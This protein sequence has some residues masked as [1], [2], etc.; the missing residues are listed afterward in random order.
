MPTNSA[1]WIT[2]AKGKPLVVKEA[3]YSSPGPDEVLIK[4]SAVAVNPVDW[5]I[6]DYNFLIQK[7]PNILGTDV[8]GEVVEVGSNVSGLNKG[9]RVIGHAFGLSTSDPKHGAFQQYTLVPSLVVAPIPSSMSFEQA[10]V[11]PLAISTASVGLF[12][13]RALGLQNP[14]MS[15]KSSGTTLLIWGGSSSVGSL[16]IQLAVA[17]GAEV[18][19]VAS[20]QNFEYCKK[21]G[22]TQ[23]FDYS[24]KTVVDKLVESL[25]GKTMVGAYDAIGGTA[26]GMVARVLSK[27]EGGK[28]IATVLEGKWEVPEGIEVVPGQTSPSSH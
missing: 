4:N 21:L 27:C 6:Q 11:L 5:K 18:I 12:E 15:P 22:A 25:R 8:A 13:K 26:N 20:K 7:Y 2:E 16:A 10:S 3:P 1:A 24:D 28:R 23:V 14:S 9:Q 19:T 17:A